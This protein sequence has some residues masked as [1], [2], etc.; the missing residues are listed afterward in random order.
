MELKPADRE[1]L[2]LRYLEQLSVDEIA[3]ALGISH[4]AVT[5]RHLNNF[6]ESH[7]PADG[8]CDFGRCGIDTTR[9]NPDSLRTFLTRNADFVVTMADAGDL[10]DVCLLVREE[11]LDGVAATNHKAV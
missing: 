3:N 5:S 8:Q 6:G 9:A 1:I 7:T 2:V 4:S 10:A 11:H